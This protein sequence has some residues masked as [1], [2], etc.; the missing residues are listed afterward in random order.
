MSIAETIA[1]CGLM[2]AII[3]VS[4]I[5]LEVHNRRLKNRERELELKVRMIEAEGRSRA[6]GVPQVEERLRVLERIVTER[7]MDL[8]AQI[9]DLR[10]EPREVEKL[11]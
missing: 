10:G 5:L 1:F 7:G 8:A 9:E 6:A 2:V 11:Q 4:G 3:C